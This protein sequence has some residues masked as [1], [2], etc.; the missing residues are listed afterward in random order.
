V[1]D[2]VIGHLWQSQLYCHCNDGWRNDGWPAC[3]AAMAVVI[4]V[5]VLI[6]VIVVIILIVGIFIIVATAATIESRPIM[7]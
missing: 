6:I 5:I 2:H 4:I 1:A 7:W 3:L